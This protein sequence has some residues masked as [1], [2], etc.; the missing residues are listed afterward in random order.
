MAKRTYFGTGQTRQLSLFNGLAAHTATQLLDGRVLIAGG[1][2]RYNSTVSLGIFYSAAPS[3]NSYIVDRLQVYLAAAGYDGQLPV[4]P[5]AGDRYRVP[6]SLSE[7]RSFDPSPTGTATVS[8]G[9]ADCTAVIPSRCKITTVTAGAKQYT[10]S[11]SGD[12]EYFPATVNA[13]RPTGTFARIERRGSGSGTVSSIERVVSGHSLF[14]VL[15]SPVYWYDCDVAI[16]PGTVLTLTASPMSVSVFVGWQGACAG[17][18]SPCSVTV[19]PSGA[20]IVRAVF[21]AST[22]MPFTLDIDQDTIASPHTDGLLVQRVLARLHD[23]ALTHA[24][25]GPN[26]LRMS[27]DLIEDRVLDMQ[28]LLDIDRNG[29]VDL[30]TD[31]VIILRYMFGFRGNAL[32]LNAIGPGARRTDPQLIAADL[33]LLMP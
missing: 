6:F 20:M 2:D 15:G 23:A 30:L 13:Q 28:P 26:A 16:P 33:A 12:L 22:A 17:T 31:G 10:V 18:T 5:V 24:A 27:A 32:T 21:A 29:E 4:S 9:S 25:L 19:P 14:C 7:L 1:F 8:D 3:A 11:Y